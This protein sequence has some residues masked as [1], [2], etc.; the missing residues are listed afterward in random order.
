MKEE[1]PHPAVEAEAGEAVGGEAGKDGAN[2]DGES[3]YEDTVAQGRLDVGLRPGIAV[4]EDVVGLREAVGLGE[5]LVDG[6]ERAE[7][8]H[9]DRDEHD[10]ADREHHKVPDRLAEHPSHLLW[11]ERPRGGWGNGG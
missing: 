6:L 8:D 3:G 9:D 1:D 2:Q 11:G 10:Q 5:Q 4:I 7:Y